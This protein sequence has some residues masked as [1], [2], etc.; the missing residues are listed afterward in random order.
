MSFRVIHHLTSLKPQLYS[1][2][3]PTSVTVSSVMFFKHRVGVSTTSEFLYLLFSLSGRPFPYVSRGCF[4]LT[5]SS[6]FLNIT[7]SES[8]SLSTL[9]KIIILLLSPLQ[10]P[11]SFD[12]ALF[13]SKAL[14]YHLK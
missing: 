10:P 7:L 9:Y 14:K 5:S 8:S 3:S 11:Y 2:S 13:S 1:F 4:S 6:L 12:F